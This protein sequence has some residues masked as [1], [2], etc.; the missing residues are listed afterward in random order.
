MSDDSIKDPQ[1]V[2]GQGKGDGCTR[3]KTTCFYAKKPFGRGHED[4]LE[5]EV[6]WN[7]F[8][9]IFELIANEGWYTDGPANW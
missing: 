5:N 7:V 9:Q 8:S 3:G 2:K 4:G 1:I 6:Q